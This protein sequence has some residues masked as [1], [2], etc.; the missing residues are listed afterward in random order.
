MSGQDPESDALDACAR[1][2]S[3]ELARTPRALTALTRALASPRADLHDRAASMV[4]KLVRAH[5]LRPQYVAPGLPGPAVDN[6]F[7]ALRTGARPDIRAL[8]AEALREAEVVRARRALIE[9]LGDDDEQVR[10]ACVRALARARFAADDLKATLALLDDERGAVRSAALHAIPDHIERALLTVVKTR[11]RACLTDRERAVRLRAVELL[12]LAAGGPTGGADAL[13]AIPLSALGEATGHGSRILQLLALRALESAGSHARSQASVIRAAADAPA[14]DVRAQAVQTLVQVGQ[15]HDVM[16]AL[17][18]ALRDSHIEP[19]QA[20]VRG[21]AQLARAGAE[22]SAVIAQVTDIMCAD[23][24]PESARC[25]AAQALGAMRATSAI[26]ALAA[27]V[28]QSSVAL[29]S[30]ALLAL[31]DYRSDDVPC[32]A[33]AP[34]VH[35]T[36]T[37]ALIGAMARPEL[38]LDACT[39]ALSL[40]LCLA[41]ARTTLATIAAD[42][43]EWQATVARGLLAAD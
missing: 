20:A 22:T 18:R 11:L 37:R 24:D 19:R 23:D 40:G 39:T 42:G 35:E 26:A 34:E 25:A 28:E 33:D 32:A 41:Q 13:L 36:T 3:T 15:P 16:E 8:A 38:A 6:L 10:Q 30:A 5:R 31:Q 12:L 17:V 43:D 1:L 2:S 14:A 29:A 7:A 27:T 21:L 4:S 9:G